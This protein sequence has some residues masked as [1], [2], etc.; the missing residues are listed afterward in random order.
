MFLLV[1][2]GMASDQKNASQHRTD[3]T[4]LNWFDEFVRPKP[5][6]TSPCRNADANTFRKELRQQSVQFELD[7]TLLREVSEDEA[8]I[9]GNDQRT[10]KGGYEAPKHVIF[11]TG[12]TVQ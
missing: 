1:L 6:L 4:V 11:S 5:A 9:K 8:R 7:C 12:T 3:R 2:L 10:I